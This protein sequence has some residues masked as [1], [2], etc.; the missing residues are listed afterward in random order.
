MPPAASGPSAPARPFGRA[1]LAW[2]AG[3]AVV[4]AA[5][6]READAG[7]PKEDVTGASD[8]RVRMGAALTLG[9]TRPVGARNELEKALFDSDK[10]VRAAAASALTTLNDPGAIPALKRARSKESDASVQKVLD[11][12]ISALEN[13]P[14]PTLTG[15]SYVLQ[16]GAVKNLTKEADVDGLVRAAIRTQCRSKLKGV[17]CVDADG[18]LVQQAVAKKIPVLVLDTQLKKLDQGSEG[19]RTTMK[20]QLEFLIR[21]SPDQTLKGSFG[22]GATT[23]GT[24]SDKAALVALRERAIDGAVESAITG[25]QK[26][27]KAATQ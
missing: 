19:G 13:P 21:K 6:A 2:A 5:A 12:S 4:L 26:G 11:K 7:D 22:G 3:F 8:Y 23:A 18:P 16:V 15:A 14:A 24:S 17:V 1:W 20:A 25:A 9:K 27:L 10:S